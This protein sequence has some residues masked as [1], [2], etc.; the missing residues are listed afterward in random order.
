V[1]L[2]EKMATYV[3][4]AEA[5]SFSAAAKQLR[6]SPAAVSR[7]IAALEAEVG[8]G[9]LLRSTRRMSITAAGRSYYER[10]VRILREVEDAQAIGRDGALD[11]ILKV[12]APVTFGLARVVPHVRALM[13]AHPGLRV[14]LRIEDRLVDLVLE[15]VD[16]AVRVGGRIPESTELVAHP[17][18]SFRRVVVAAPAYVKR[19]GVPRTP[20]ALAKHDALTYSAGAG[21]DVWTLSSGDREARVRVNA[22]FQ[23][24]APDALRELATGGAGIALLP[25]FLVAADLEARSLQR[26]LPAWETAPVPVSALHRTV[27]RGALRV[28]ALIDHLRAAYA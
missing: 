14:D 18:S 4:V 23:S 19:K 9:L 28:R 7:Q 13:A 6:I 16:V 26:L 11:G 25:D 12:S 21:S 10:C 8:V 15:D 24:T 2:L 27:H 22:T 5:G 3:R 17:L 20:E 1:D